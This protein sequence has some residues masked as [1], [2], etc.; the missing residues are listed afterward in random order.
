MYGSDYCE[1][2]AP[3]AKFNTVKIYLAIAA[4][5]KCKV[6]QLDVKKVYL[7]AEIGK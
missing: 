6:L 1:T 2:F 4:M 3:T 7:N 5:S